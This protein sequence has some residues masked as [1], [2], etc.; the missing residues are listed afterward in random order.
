MT[1]DVADETSCYLC[2]VCA[3]KLGSKQGARRKARPRKRTKAMS[4][5]E[6]IENNKKDFGSRIIPF[7]AIV[8]KAKLTPG[9]KH[10]LGNVAPLGHDG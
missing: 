6:L 5:D 2:S 7:R 10:V 9:Q 8:R 1:H 4:D 3:N